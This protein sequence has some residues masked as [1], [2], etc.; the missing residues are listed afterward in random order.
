M[1]AQSSFV[2]QWLLASLYASAPITVRNGVTGH[3]V[4][5]AP[6]VGPAL[7]GKDKETGRAMDYV[8]PD[9]ELKPW[10]HPVWRAELIRKAEDEEK[11]RKAAEATEAREGEVRQSDRG[12]A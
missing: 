8:V 6:I 9:Y 3:T 2:G 12:G 1:R 10:L 4:S 7:R 5:Q 11:K